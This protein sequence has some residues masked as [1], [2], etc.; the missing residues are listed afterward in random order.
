MVEVVGTLRHPTSDPLTPT[1]FMGI[2]I[3]SLTIF[4]L[5]FTVLSYFRCET[6]SASG[7]GNPRF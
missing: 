7:S 4:V 2:K 1:D 5:V 3:A 6:L